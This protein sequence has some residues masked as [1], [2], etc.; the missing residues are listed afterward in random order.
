MLYDNYADPHQQV[1]LAGRTPYQ[2]VLQDLRRRLLARMK[3]A[4]DPTATI[5]PSWFPYP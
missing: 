5:E 1:N 3:E 2:P 4:G